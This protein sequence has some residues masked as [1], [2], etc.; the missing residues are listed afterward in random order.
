[1]EI[2]GQVLKIKEDAQNKANKVVLATCLGWV[3]IVIPSVWFIDLK[4]RE[5]S[6]SNI[7][8]CQFLQCWL[9]V[10][11]AA[12]S[13]FAVYQ[14]SKKKTKSKKLVPNDNLVDIISQSLKS[15][16]FEELEQIRKRLVLDIEMCDI[17]IEKAKKIQVTKK[18]IATFINQHKK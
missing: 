15:S 1:M 13:L 7:D 4:S 16:A 10:S 11:F 5:K 12:T 3:N 2:C 18:E 6:R 9:G 17:Y 14:F 8:F